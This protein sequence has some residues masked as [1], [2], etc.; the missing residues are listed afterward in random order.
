[1]VRA[2]KKSN[3]VMVRKDN[4]SSECI[5]KFLYSYGGK[6]LPRY[7]DSKL[8]YVGGE[9][10]VLSVDRTSISFSGSIFD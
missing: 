7:P 2:T 9:T 10:R 1:M 5:I 8:R 6:I 3:S 4:I